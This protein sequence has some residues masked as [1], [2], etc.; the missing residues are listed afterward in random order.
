MPIFVPEK[1]G[2]KI[3]RAC[4]IDKLVLVPIQFSL[5]F[6]RKMTETIENGIS[7]IRKSAKKTINSFLFLKEE[8]KKLKRVFFIFFQVVSVGK[9]KLKKY[10]EERNE[11]SIFSD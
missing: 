3:L 1:V 5:P 2:I 4:F 11:E 9:K 8:R 7:S 6:R 10:D